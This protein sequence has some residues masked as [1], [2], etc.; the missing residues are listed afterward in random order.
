MQMY[1]LPREC[2]LGIRRILNLEHITESNWTLMGEVAP[3]VPLG[4]PMETMF[5]NSVEVFNTVILDNVLRFVSSDKIFRI[6]E[7]ITNS[8][9]GLMFEVGFS[10]LRCLFGSHMDYLEQNGYDNQVAKLV[11]RHINN[12]YLRNKHEFDLA[13][14]DLLESILPFLSYQKERIIRSSFINKDTPVVFLSQEG[15]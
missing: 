5:Q 3:V 13:V 14:I 8:T 2:N 1:V 9:L 4:A 7:G 11:S 15:T 12:L 10:H 6:M